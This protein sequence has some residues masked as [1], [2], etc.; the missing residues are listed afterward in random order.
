MRDKKFHSKS[1]II[2]KNI[3]KYR[4][5]IGYN[6]EQLC[7]KLD[8]FRLNL[9]HS[10]IYLIEHNKRLVRDYEV[11]AFWKVFNN[12]FFISSFCTNI[13]NCE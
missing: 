13:V 11:L 5:M 2:S 6:Q 4:T 8:L 10:D 7:T 1:N 9:Y 3:K 12:S